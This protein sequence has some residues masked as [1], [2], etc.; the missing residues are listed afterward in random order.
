MADN[1]AITAGS[2]TPIATDNVGGVNY[3]RSKVVWGV[4]GV[5]TD[6]STAAPLP[7]EI[8]PNGGGG[9][10]S[11]YKSSAASINATVVKAS[12]GVL[13][14][15]ALY[16]NSSA[17]AYLRLYDK[18]TAP[19][20]ADTPVGCHGIPGNGG[21]APPLQQEFATGISYTLTTGAADNNA[22]AVTLDQ[23][24]VNIGYV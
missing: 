15:L 13:Y 6:A 17:V 23:V 5:V 4:D 10:S 16:N 20:G 18:A 24:K 1:V 8:V 9:N 12:A 7:V 3:Q 22:S 11:H 21:T 2:G 19:S 14:S